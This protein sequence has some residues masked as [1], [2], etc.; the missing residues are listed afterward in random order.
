M[1]LSFRWRNIQADLALS[2]FNVP[3]EMMERI[4]AEYEAQDEDPLMDQALDIH[5]KTGRDVGELIDELKK[6]RL[7]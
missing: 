6:V 1:A 2:G 5:E 7:Q 4:A 3:D